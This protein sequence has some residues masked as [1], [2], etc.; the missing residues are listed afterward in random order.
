VDSEAGFDYTL[1]WFDL[2]SGEAGEWVTLETLPGDGST[3]EFMDDPNPTQ[4]VPAYR[5]LIEVSPP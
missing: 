1:Q 5:V 4:A 2:N 3:L